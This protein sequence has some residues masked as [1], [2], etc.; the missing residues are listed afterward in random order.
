M[1]QST[2]AAAATPFNNANSYLGVGD[3]TTAF[4]AS[5]TDLIASTNRLR[6]AM[7]ATYPSGASNVITFRSTFATGDANFAWNEW[8]VFNNSTFGS[9]T[10]LSRKQEALGTKLSSQTWQLTAVLTFTTA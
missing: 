4:A 5:Q 10:M 2:I 7:D 9:G 6:K 8:G 1:V 3:S